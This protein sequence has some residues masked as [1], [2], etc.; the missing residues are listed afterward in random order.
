VV[1][2]VVLE[3]VEAALSCNGLNKRLVGDLFKDLDLCAWLGSSVPPSWYMAMTC[4][5]GMPSLKNLN[6]TP[7]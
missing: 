3:E 6:A 4:E 2:Q 7:V 1:G 5:A